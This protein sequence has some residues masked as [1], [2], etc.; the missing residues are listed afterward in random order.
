MK[1]E[2]TIKN[3]IAGTHPEILKDIHQSNVNI[4]IYNR[5]ILTLTK[6]TN[7]L[8]KRDL[9]IDVNGDINSVLNEITMQIDADEFPL[10]VED[11]RK[12]LEHF[13]DITNTSGIRLLLETVNTNMCRRFHTDNNDLRMICTYSGPGTLWLLEENINR[14]A[15][16]SYGDNKSIVMDE[17]EIQQAK[18]G[19]VIILKGSAYPKEGTIAVVH[20]SPTI[21]ESSDRRLLLRI[22]THKIFSFSG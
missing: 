16:D 5:D 2:T 20:R 13:S 15:L 18:T 10:I 12:L 21:E 9:K 17:S 7:K 19:S 22:D 3:Y 14:T 4:A 8:L 6:E 11:I 1:T